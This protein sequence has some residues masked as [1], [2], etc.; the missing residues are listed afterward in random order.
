VRRALLTT[1]VIV[2]AVGLL[3]RDDGT[4]SRRDCGT[5]GVPPHPEIGGELIYNCFTPA[6]STGFYLLDVAT[7]KVRTIIAD[8]AWNTDPAWSP[9]GS[10]IAY[11]STKDGQTDIY[12]MELA[13]GAVTRLT[14]SGGWNGNPTWSPDGA[15]IMFDSSRDGVSKSPHNYFRNLFVV[16]LDGRDLHRVTALPRYNGTPAWSPDG[17]RVAFTSDRSDRYTLYTM[18]TDGGDVM[19]LTSWPSGYAR[20]SPDGA[21]VLFHGNEPGDMSEDEDTTPSVY[22]MPA[23]GGPPQRLTSGD[24]L[25]PDWAP[26]AHWISFARKIGEGRELFVMPAGGGDAIQLTFD[27]SDKAWARWRPR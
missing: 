22:V 13:S 19:G 20:W 4:T 27:G 26:D 25:M 6:T 14:S 18:S 10:R 15:W 16:R 8:H 17:K 2:F 12:V 23:I 21:R 9:D 5:A 7:G 3:A 24:D 1:A 11:V